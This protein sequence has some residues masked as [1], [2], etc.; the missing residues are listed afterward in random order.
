MSITRKYLFDNAF[1]ALKPSRPAPPPAR[2][3]SEAEVKA[4][5]ES[6]FAQGREAGTRE[7]ESGREQLVARSTAAMAEGLQ[8]VKAL[9][10]EL[11]LRMTRWALQS[12][13]GM[14]QKLFPELVRR[15]GQSEIE[16]MVVNT[17]Q[18]V[19]D[20][21]RVVV[22][23]P[24]AMIEPMQPAVAEIC[25]QAGFVGRLLLIEDD[26]IA[27]GDCRVEWAEG[28]IE[29]QAQR[30]WTDIEQRVLRLLAHPTLSDPG[31]ETG[32]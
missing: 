12:A 16:A 31:S 13:L 9:N 7:V 8:A 1:D 24:A 21:P 6:A 11:E 5:C 2:R 15:H 10:A 32:R 27:L 17:L 19:E 22:R 28:G 26:A 25:R 3:F 18:D 20:E 29:R 30:L 4:A 14:V 23:M